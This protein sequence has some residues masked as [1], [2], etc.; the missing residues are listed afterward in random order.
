MKCCNMITINC[1]VIVQAETGQGNK[2]EVAK[3][4]SLEEGV[5]IKRCIEYTGAADHVS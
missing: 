3:R 4:R 5:A 2:R 1:A